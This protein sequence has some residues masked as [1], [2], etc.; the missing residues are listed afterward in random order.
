[1]GMVVIGPRRFKRGGNKMELSREPLDTQNGRYH[2]P[3]GYT[4]RLVMEGFATPL[5]PLM[6]AERE[7]GT[8]SLSVEGGK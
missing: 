4:T 7:R 8:A 1:M 3:H 5:S 2:R 6:A